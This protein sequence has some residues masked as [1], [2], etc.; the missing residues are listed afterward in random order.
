MRLPQPHAAGE[1]QPSPEPPCLG[2]PARAAWVPL[3]STHSGSGPLLGARPDFLQTDTG[4]RARQAAEGREGG[5]RAVGCPDVRRKPHPTP[6][7]LRTPPLLQK[8]S[9]FR[10]PGGEPPERPR[11]WARETAKEAFGGGEPAEAGRTGC[12]RRE[13]EGSGRERQGHHSLRRKCN[14]GAWPT[15]L[16]F[17]RALV[18][19]GALSSP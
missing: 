16:S 11:E 14:Y 10:G 17:S 3:C 1:G 18:G 12:Y 19:A 15:S 7:L 2:R 8:A 6:Y 4:Q 13:R 9:R 5:L